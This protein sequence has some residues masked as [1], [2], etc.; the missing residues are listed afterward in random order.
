V[1][2]HGAE[3]KIEAKPFEW[4]RIVLPLFILPAVKK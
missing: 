3:I 1:G 2:D 4:E